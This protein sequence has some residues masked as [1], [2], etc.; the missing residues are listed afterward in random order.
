MSF[1]HLFVFGQVGNLSGSL[2]KRVRSWV[3]HIPAE[4]LQFFA[5]HF[6]T[7][8][9]KKLTD[10]FHLNLEKDFPQCLWLLPF[11]FGKPKPDNVNTS[12]TREVTAENICDKIMTTDITTQ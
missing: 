2:V 7:E 4:R 6:S 5:M 1:C 12:A 9:W 11:C 10:V 8:P 3:R